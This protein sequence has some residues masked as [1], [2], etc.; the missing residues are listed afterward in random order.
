M[1]FKQYTEASKREK[2]K[3]GVEI[4]ISALPQTTLRRW[5]NLRKENHSSHEC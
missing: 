2:K 5:E 1:A 4:L 3:K